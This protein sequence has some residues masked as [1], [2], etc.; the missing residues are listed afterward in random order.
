MTKRH[1]WSELKSNF[2]NQWVELVDCEWTSD[3]PHPESACVRHT[4]PERSR[5]VSKIAG[6]RRLSDSAIIFLGHQAPVLE[7]DP[8]APVF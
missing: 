2:K 1:T 4:D 5:L 8:S 3:R 7:L 6:S